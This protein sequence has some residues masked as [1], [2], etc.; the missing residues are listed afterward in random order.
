MLAVLA[1]VAGVVGA[2]A[3]F[4]SRDKGSTSTRGS[5]AGV[6]DSA[7]TGRLLRAGNVEIF[8][9]NPADGARLRALAGSLGASDTPQ[10][11]AAGQ[12]VVLR[13]QTGRNGVL[14]RA[15]RHSLRARSAADPRLQ[16][17]VETWLGAPT[18]P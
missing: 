18:S 15:W 8:Y 3:F 5:G 13:L 7:A 9:A 14:A 6:V 4:T 2:I 16:D 12:A 1:A 10:L 11:R 17:F